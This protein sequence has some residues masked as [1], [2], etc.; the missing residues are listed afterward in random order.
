MAER[1][2]VP[3]DWAGPV[4][5][6]GGKFHAI[7]EHDGVEQSI[8]CEWTDYAASYKHPAMF[9]KFRMELPFSPRFFRVDI[10]LYPISMPD[11]KI[12]DLKDPE[13]QNTFLNRF[14]SG[15]YAR[16]LRGGRIY[17]KILS[18]NTER[19]QHWFDVHEEK[20]GAIEAHALLQQACNERPELQLD[21]DEIW[22]KMFVL[23]KSEMPAKVEKI[24]KYAYDLLAE[25]KNVPELLDWIH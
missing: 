14:N 7:I 9:R 1:V 10:N 22:E 6:D 20:A 16:Y 25:G 19:K 18:K 13:D 17:V 4:E 15:S 24:R 21:L 2:E 5:V 3:D 11:V 8:M 12:P 23:D